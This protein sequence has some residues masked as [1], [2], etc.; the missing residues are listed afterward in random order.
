MILEAL[1]FL[2]EESWWLHS[3][4]EAAW[5]VL[6]YRR[7]PAGPTIVYEPGTTARGQQSPSVDPSKDGG[8]AGN[9][10][11]DGL[12][13]PAAQGGKLEGVR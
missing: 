2:S 1:S 8:Q 6:S 7:Y 4:T 10:E 12:V 9:T 5:P 3:R 11:V 13:F